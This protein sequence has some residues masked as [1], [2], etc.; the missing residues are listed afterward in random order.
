MSTTPPAQAVDAPRTVSPGSERPPA[1]SSPASAQRRALSPWQI[2][3]PFA[4]LLFGSL[5]V[6]AIVNSKPA[7]EGAEPPPRVAVVEAITV[8]PEKVRLSVESQGTVRPRVQTRLTAEVGGRVESVSPN[9]RPG[10]FIRQGEALVRLD[11]TDYEAAVA[12][13]K[14]N[15]AQARFNL[16]QE[17][18]LAEQAAADWEDLGRGEATDLA[19]RKPQLEQARSAIQSAEAALT[20]AERD[21]ERTEVRAPYDGRVTEQSV[22]VGQFVGPNT[23]LGVIYG[24]DV[25]EVFLPLDTGELSRLELPANLDQR[26]VDGPPVRLSATFGAE[27]YHWEGHLARM[28]AEFDSRSRL[29]D[30]VAAVEDPL[31]GD[32]AQPSRPA[33]RPG[34][35]VEATIEGREVAGAFAIPRRALR[36]GDTVL[37]AKPDDTLAQRSVTVIQADTKRAIISEG[38]EPGDRV[39]VSPMEYVVDGMNLRVTES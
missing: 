32:P 25:A 27:T 22:D 30:A 33:L 29:L 11:P 38:L 5:A 4:I 19:L 16:A 8:Q 2:I 7:P 36:E 35:F 15:L 37:V 14:A 3:L 13:A 9:F 39:I 18:A 20:R 12:N 23:A 21:L 17:E 10:G 31:G 24:T 34:M 1:P 26:G 6:Y 28:G